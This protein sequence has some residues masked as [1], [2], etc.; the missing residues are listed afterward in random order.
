MP[1]AERGMI[2]Y[3]DLDDP[4]LYFPR[5]LPL[6]GTALRLQDGGVETVFR[7]GSFP[8]VF[9]ALFPHLAETKVAETI[10]DIAGQVATLCVPTSHVEYDRAKVL[11]TGSLGKML[12]ASRL[13]ERFY[14]PRKIF[15]Q[16]AREYPGIDTFGELA[17]PAIDVDL[18]FQLPR[19][20][21]ISYLEAI[22]R[23]VA[24]KRKLSLPVTVVNRHIG[25]YRSLDTQFGDLVK[26]DLGELP[27]YSE[28][29]PWLTNTRMAFPGSV[30]DQYCVAQ[31][32][33]SGVEVSGFARVLLQGEDASM[34]IEMADIPQAM[35]VGLRASFN[36]ILFPPRFNFVLPGTKALWP[37]LEDEHHWDAFQTHSVGREHMVAAVQP[38]VTNGLL[39]NILCCPKS[40]ILLKRVH[41]LDQIP[42][43]ERLTGEAIETF[44]ESVRPDYDAI[45]R[46]GGLPMEDSGPAILARFLNREIPDLIPLMQLQ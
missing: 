39:L 10:D 2:G 3:L 21:E 13:P 9:Y 11:I 15:G 35:V 36:R 1:A 23:D 33:G 5:F 32:T 38:Q 34:A 37:Y 41:I 17:S 42:L 12:A 29:D 44:L 40:L 8:E 26:L 22:V 45:F 30:K 7:Y 27:D 6:R 14:R 28:L 16:L 31:Y 24:Q 43:G 19:G 46:Y 4:R 20:L 18:R 25:S